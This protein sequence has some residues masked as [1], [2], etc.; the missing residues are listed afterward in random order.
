M[1]NTALLERPTTQTRHL[2]AVTGDEASAPV[3]PAPRAALPAG[4]TPRGFALYVGIDE[5]KAAEAG[6]SDYFLQTERTR[7]FAKVSTALGEQLEQDL[8]SAVK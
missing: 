6:K 4:T 3:A 2:H 5:T 7:L 1:S 8:G